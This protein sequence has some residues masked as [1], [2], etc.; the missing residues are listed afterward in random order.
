MRHYKNEIA[1]RSKKYDMVSVYLPKGERE[2][3]KQIA[4]KEN[5][6]L[7]EWIAEAIKQKREK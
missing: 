4:A 6:S 5:K 2:K 7:N 3:L 1:W